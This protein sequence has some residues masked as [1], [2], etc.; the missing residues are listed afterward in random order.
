MD[1]NDFLIR[2]GLNAEGVGVP[3]V[4]L[5]RKRKLLELFLTGAAGDADLFV[6][7]AVIAA[8][9]NEALDLRVD[10]GKLFLS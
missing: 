6:Y 10:L 2:N 9:L 5:T 4:C 1:S 7:F 8:R 3:K